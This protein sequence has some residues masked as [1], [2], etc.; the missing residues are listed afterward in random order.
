M[1]AA[2]AALLLAGCAAGTSPPGSPPGSPP[3]A[4]SGTA[5]QLV[6]YETMPAGGNAIRPSRPD[7]FQLQ[8]EVD[9]RLVARLDCNRGSGTWRS[10]ASGALQLGAMAST[11]M[12]CPPDPLN[13]KLPA[14]M[15]SVRRYRTD[16]D[17]LFLYLQ[18][19]TGMYTWQRTSR[20]AVQ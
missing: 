16:G 11:K 2:G 5:W 13:M 8:F 10:P 6:S 4:L 3:Q 12:M 7:Q 20:G 1:L 19:D 15:A 17:R 14:D 9:G 18:G